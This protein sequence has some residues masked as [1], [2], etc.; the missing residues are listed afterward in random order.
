MNTKNIGTTTEIFN[1]LNK[2]CKLNIENQIKLLMSFIMSDTE[3]YQE[4]ANNLL[5]E[6]C[7]D[8]FKEKKINNLTES[9]ASN[10]CIILENMKD[11]EDNE[12]GE[13][14]KNKERR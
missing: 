11:G 8:I 14:Q 12:K 1:G 2:Q 4:E 10:L 13:N 5:L 6:K 3:K 7:K 9:I